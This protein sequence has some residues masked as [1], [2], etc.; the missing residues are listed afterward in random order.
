MR[1]IIAGTPLTIGGPVLGGNPLKLA[2][3]TPNFYNFAGADDDHG[4]A[5]DWPPGINVHLQISLHTCRYQV[6]GRAMR[7]SM[8]LVMGGVRGRWACDGHT[9]GIRRA[10]DEWV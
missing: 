8:Q 3:G 10:Y 2:G 9:T 6:Y 7:Q 1:L 5:C 4:W